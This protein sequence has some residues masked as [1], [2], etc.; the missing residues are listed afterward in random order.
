MVVCLVGWLILFVFSLIG[1][2]TTSPKAQ[3]HGSSV[4]DDPRTGPTSASVRVRGSSRA[5]AG[6]VGISVGT[7]I[8]EPTGQNH[9]SSV[10]ILTPDF[11]IGKY[12]VRPVVGNQRNKHV[13]PRGE[14]IGYLL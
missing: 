10:D 12:P 5:E 11:V 9:W 13:K 4:K 1:I 8:L 2:I 7:S 14:T 6:E 3:V